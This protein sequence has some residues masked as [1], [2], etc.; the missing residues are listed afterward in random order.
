MQVLDI[1]AL[2]NT[3][4]RFSRP[5]SIYLYLSAIARDNS[6][7]TVWYVFSKGS[8]SAHLLINCEVKSPSKG[9]CFVLAGSD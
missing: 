3:P 9:S 8:P 6:I 2:V 7:D 1:Y 5:A 4:T